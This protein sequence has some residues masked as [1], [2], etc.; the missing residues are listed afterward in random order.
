ML[1]PEVEKVVDWL[2]CEVNKGKQYVHEKTAN[3]TFFNV[4][5][6]PFAMKPLEGVDSRHILWEYATE[7]LHDMPEVMRTF[8]VFCRNAPKYDRMEKMALEDIVSPTLV[9]VLDPKWR[10]LVPATVCA[11][12]AWLFAY[13]APENEQCFN[14]A[15]AWVMVDGEKF[16]IVDRYLHCGDPEFDGAA[17]GFIRSVDAWL[18]EPS[19]Q[20]S[21]RRW[22]TPYAQKLR[23][24][25]TI[26]AQHW[27]ALI[28][29]LEDANN[30]E[31][32]A[33]FGKR[34]ELTAGTIK[35]VAKIVCDEDVR[36]PLKAMRRALVPKYITRKEWDLMAITLEME[37]PRVWSSDARK[38]LVEILRTYQA[39]FQRDREKAAQAKLVA[40]SLGAQV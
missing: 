29:V 11:A 33:F 8:C 10:K 30:G 31:I 38:G 36:D 35:S 3:S 6:P 1:D 7:E 18:K 15:N 40:R 20:M 14:E 26:S 16:G 2:Y 34:R 22:W 17:F 28:G 25:E 27:M 19:R 4:R 32:K 24:H 13:K 9:A 37:R 21:V 12:L 39:R 5:M 23:Q